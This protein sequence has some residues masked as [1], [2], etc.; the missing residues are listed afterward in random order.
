MLRRLAIVASL[1][2]AALVVGVMVTNSGPRSFVDGEEFVLAAHSSDATRLAA[3]ARSLHV[4]RGAGPSLARGHALGRRP[5][6]PAR[7][8]WGFE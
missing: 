6:Q 3:L 2:F 5:R 7:R 1:A 8:G 4:Q